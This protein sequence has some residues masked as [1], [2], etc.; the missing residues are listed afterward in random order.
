MVVAARSPFGPW[1]G[2]RMWSIPP[3]NV[4]N[5]PKYGRSLFRKMFPVPQNICVLWKL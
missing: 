4:K 1:F 5:K 2:I 3:I